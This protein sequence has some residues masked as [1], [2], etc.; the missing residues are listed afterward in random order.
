MLLGRGFIRELYVHMGFDP[1]WKYE[2]V[3]EL[4]FR[5][6]ALTEAADRSAGMAALR[7]KMR[8]DPLKPGTRASRGEIEE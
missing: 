7:E 3:H 2:E 6:G 1:A 4:L 8:G 5:E